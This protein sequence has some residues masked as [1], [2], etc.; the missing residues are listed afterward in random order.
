MEITG[1]R[2]QLLGPRFACRGTIRKSHDQ[3]FSRLRVQFSNALLLGAP[4]SILRRGLAPQGLVGA[5]GQCQLAGMFIR[6]T[7]EADKCRRAT[8]VDE[9]LPLRR[10]HELT[11]QRIC[12]MSQVLQPQVDCNSASDFL[13]SLSPVGPFFKDVEPGETWLF[14]GQGFDWSLI[15]SAL[16][17]G[18][19]VSCFDSARY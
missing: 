11:P 10:Y 18:W 8:A 16:R 2:T 14:R 1:G 17:D 9:I 6:F 7:P 4:L 12:L 13:E 19:Q 3:R 15:P 5:L